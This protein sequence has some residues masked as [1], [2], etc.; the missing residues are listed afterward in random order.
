VGSV[1]WLQVD[2]IG[3]SFVYWAIDYLGQIFENYKSSINFG[4]TFYHGKICVF[5]LTKNGPGYIF[6]YFF[7]DSSCHPGWWPSPAAIRSQFLL[8]KEKW[9][10]WSNNPLPA[11]KLCCY[12]LQSVKLLPSTKHRFPIFGSFVRKQ[13]LN[14]MLRISSLRPVYTR[15]KFCVARQK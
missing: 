1:I 4:P 2:Q 13:I 3:R 7:T 12:F 5:I 10:V 14:T 8:N 15:H 6:S 9:K 11:K